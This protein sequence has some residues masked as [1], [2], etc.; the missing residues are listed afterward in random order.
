MARSYATQAYLTPRYA[1]Q[2]L[3]SEWGRRCYQNVWVDYALRTAKE[4]LEEGV[5][6]WPTRGTTVERA[7]ERADGVVISDV[8]F[9]N[10]VLAIQAAGGKV[11]RIVRKDAGLKGA[12]SQ[13]ASETEQLTIPVE[14]FDANL[15]NGGMGLE[16]L[17]VAVG[18]LVETLR[19]V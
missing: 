14:L 5:E 11:V 2:Q 12:A 16:L 4:V 17:E 19:L 15:I 3:G 10:E 13:H 6:Y 8:R 1:L 9:R 7:D 18:G